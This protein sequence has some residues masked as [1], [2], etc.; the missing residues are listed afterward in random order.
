MSRTHPRI[1]VVGASLAGLTLA[2]ACA[3]R[4]VPVHVVS[5][6]TGSGFATGVEDAAVLAS[7][8][9]GRQ[10][11]EPLSAALTRCDSARLPCVRA[12]VG[13]S[14]KLSAEFLRYATS[15]S[16]GGPR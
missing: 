5:P 1:V 11:D 16:S 13:H 14:R 9:A 15:P 2:L 8:L 12:L 6:M 3:A 7:L 10:P 4:G